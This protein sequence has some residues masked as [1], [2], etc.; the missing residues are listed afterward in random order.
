MNEIT[1]QKKSQMKLFGMQ[2]P[3]QSILESKQ[4]HALDN[5]EP[6]E[7]TREKL[8]FLITEIQYS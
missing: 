6:M 7:I 5:D 3:F 1:L 8:A 2:E 4:Y